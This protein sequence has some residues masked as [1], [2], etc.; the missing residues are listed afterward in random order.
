TLNEAD[1][2]FLVIHYGS[3]DFHAVLRKAPMEAEYDAFKAKVTALY[4]T[5]SLAQVTALAAEEFPGQVYHLQDLFIE[6]RRRVTGIILHA[7]FNEYQQAFAHLADQD[8]DLI[9]RIGRLHD[10]MPR[11][12]RTALS[13][14][15][16]R[17]IAEAAP[18]LQSDDTVKQIRQILDRGKAW[19]YQP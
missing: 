1:T 12:M 17:R 8:E 3:L 5:G 11:G 10:P 19:D 2:A 16:D 13:V 18:N 4:Q 14:T 15:I 7:R 9:Y 6:E